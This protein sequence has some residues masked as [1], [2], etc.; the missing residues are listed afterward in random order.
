[1]TL[2]DNRFH[3]STR[4][5]GL[6]EIDVYRVPKILTQINKPSIDYSHGS[7]IHHLKSMKNLI[8]SNASNPQPQIS[9]SLS[10]RPTELSLCKPPTLESSWTN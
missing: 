6:R 3:H 8:G 1:M 9:I 2:V 7:L 10:I 5:K 4:M